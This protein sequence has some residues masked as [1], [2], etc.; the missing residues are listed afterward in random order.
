MRTRAFV[1]VVSLIAV[2]APLAPAQDA[3]P[4]AF[5]TYFRCSEATE[6]RADEIY[7]ELIEPAIEKQ[8]EAGHLTAHGW[9]R[10]WMGGDWRRIGYIVAPDVGSLVAAR[11]GYFEAITGENAN[12]LDEFNSICSS[13]DDYIWRAVTGSQQPAEVGTERAPVGMSTYFECG[14]A[15]AE[16]DAIVGA[17]FA[18]VMNKHVEEKKIGTWSWMRHMAGGE[19]R[20]ALIFDGA[21]HTSVLEY[22]GQLVAALNE[23][24][25]F[26]WQRF[27]E[28]CPSHTDYVWDLGTN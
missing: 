25:P 14:P 10:H 12:A 11:N 20:R 21:D 2:S 23:S 5:G 8:K 6:A 27:R 1:G 28:A 13:H 15:E 24:H 22:W 9:G 18:A 26:A 16:A 4:V 7:K 3:T 17:A 19:Y